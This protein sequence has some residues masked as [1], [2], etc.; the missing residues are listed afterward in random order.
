MIT[1]RS[2]RFTAHVSTNTHKNQKHNNQNISY[3]TYRNNMTYFLTYEDTILTGN[4]SLVHRSSCT[5]L[6]WAPQFVADG[7]EAK[8]L[9]VF[10]ILCQTYFLRKFMS[11]PEL[12]AHDCE[13]G[14][15]QCFWHQSHKCLKP[16]LAGYTSRRVNLL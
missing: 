4:A 7:R 15:A 6:H 13:D 5:R 3:L 1:Y 12:S 10:S 11:L 16:A 8:R 14:R 2:C 9:V